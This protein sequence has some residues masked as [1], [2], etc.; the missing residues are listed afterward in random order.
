ML[1]EKEIIEEARDCGYI[2]NKIAS[3]LRI[4][5]E[6]GYADERF[7]TTAGSLFLLDHWTVFLSPDHTSQITVKQWSSVEQAQREFRAFRFPLDQIAVF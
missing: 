4:L 6:E 7:E 5:C 1:T 3:A 2:G